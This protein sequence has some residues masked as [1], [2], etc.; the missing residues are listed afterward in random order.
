MTPE[1]IRAIPAPTLQTKLQVEVCAQVGE[2]KEAILQLLSANQLILNALK[3]ET[4]KKVEPAEEVKKV[5]RV[6]VK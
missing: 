4:S 3:R 6:S 1:E 2:L 5:E